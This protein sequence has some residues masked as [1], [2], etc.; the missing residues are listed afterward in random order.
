YLGT[1]AIGASS[2]L[3][4]TLTI[5]AT[6]APG[7]YT[8]GAIADYTNRRAETTETNNSLSATQLVITPGADLVMTALSGPATAT[9]GTSVVLSSTVTNHGPG[10]SAGFYVGLYLS[11]DPVITTA[12][13]RLGYRWVSSLG[14]AGTATASSTASTTVTIP[15]AV[16]AGPY[17]LGAIADFEIPNR[18]KES[19]ETN[20]AL[21]GSQITVG[22]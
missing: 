13:R 22:P 7:T 20:N 15:T 12:D 1:L 18:V 21:A 6:L 19:N 2:T 5:P 4:T 11:T 17:T 10:S 16:T 8:L 3:T 14:A 9:R